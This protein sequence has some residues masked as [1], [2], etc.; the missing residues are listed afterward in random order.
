MQ[1]VG[2]DKINIK[3]L[4]ALKICHKGKH[5]STNNLNI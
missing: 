4:F 5:I 2:G 1:D 3:Y